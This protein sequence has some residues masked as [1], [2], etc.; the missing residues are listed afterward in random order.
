[1]FENC[2]NS[3]SCSVKNCEYHE[4]PNHCSANVVEIS[5]S[6]ATTSKETLCSTFKPCENCK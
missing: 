5:N 1:M 3:V 4:A 2:K 6:K